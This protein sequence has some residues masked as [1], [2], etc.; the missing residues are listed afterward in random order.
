[1]IYVEYISRRPGVGVREFHEQMLAAQHAWAAA[2]GEDVLLW[3]GGRTW[4]LGPEPEYLTVWH[5]PGSGLER[6]DAWD[7]D[8]RAGGA[9]RH[10]AGFARVARID[11]AGC[12]QALLEPVPPGG[13]GGGGAPGASTYYL[14][15]FRAAGPLPAVTAAFGERAARQAR[16]R[17][18][19]LAHR[20]GLL[21]PD[22]GGLAL[23]ALPDLQSLADLNAEADGRDGPVERVVAGVYAAVGREIL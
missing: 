21:G 16:A 2:H 17:L 11:R 1:M 18:L 10:E 14:E 8:F 3:A 20:I 15:H 12:Y 9:E 23:W 6:L 5:S 19:L 7:A 13:T 22:P 4:R